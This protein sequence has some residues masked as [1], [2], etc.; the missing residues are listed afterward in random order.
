[1]RHHSLSNEN[2]S[3]V[4]KRKRTLQNILKSQIQWQMELGRPIAIRIPKPALSIS[5]D[6]GLGTSD[7]YK[8][9]RYIEQV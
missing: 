6:R 5:L 8:E 3:T 2:K 7:I 4:Q 1:M 9:F